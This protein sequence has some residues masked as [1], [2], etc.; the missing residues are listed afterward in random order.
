MIIRRA[1]IAAA[2]ASVITPKKV[3]A[4]DKHVIHDHVVKNMQTD[5]EM[6]IKQTKNEL[7]SWKA[8][9]GFDHVIESYS[10]DAIL[11][12][13]SYMMVMYDV[14]L[15]PYQRVSV[16]KKLLKML[17]SAK[18]DQQAEYIVNI[19]KYYGLYKDEEII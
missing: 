3:M 16:S 5:K 13:L 15:K 14:P 1:L 18:S 9:Q 7:K 19:M 4:F 10:D 12:E 6:A 2:C 8:S 11:D 17:D